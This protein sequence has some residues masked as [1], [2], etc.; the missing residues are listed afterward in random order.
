MLRQDMRMIQ[1]IEV[2]NDD[3]GT[4]VKTGKQIK[5]LTPKHRTET[6]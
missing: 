4:D 2:L 1:T 5:V 6:Y 3:K